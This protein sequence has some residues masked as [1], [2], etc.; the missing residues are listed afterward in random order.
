[1]TM[2]TKRKPSLKQV[3]N[4]WLKYN[5]K[6]SEAY[7]AKSYVEQLATQCDAY[8]TEL[9][10]HEGNVYRISINKNIWNNRYE[11]NKI[12]EV[13]ELPANSSEKD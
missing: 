5:R 6:S 4:A 12:A 11:I 9:I 8:S 2:T 3:F 1:M 10:E 7:K 13:S